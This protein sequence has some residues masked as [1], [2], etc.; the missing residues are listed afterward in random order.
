MVS[1]SV[2]TRTRAWVRLRQGA[3]VHTD[4]DGVTR[5]VCPSQGVSLGELDAAALTALTMLSDTDVDDREL[6]AGVFAEHGPSGVQGAHALLAELRAGNWLRATLEHNGTALVTVCPLGERFADD[7]RSAADLVSDVLSGM[8]RPVVRP[9]VMSRFALLRRD[10]R[11]PLLESPRSAFG[12]RIQHSPL[13]SVLGELATP[14]PIASLTPPDGL[15]PEAFAAV[16]G[17]LMACRLVVPVGSGE[18]TDFDLLQWS[19]HE[20]WFHA[21]TRRTRHESPWG[22]TYWAKGRFDPLPATHVPLGGT[23]LPLFR[24]NMDAV[25]ARDLSLTQVLETRRSLRRH[26]DTSPLTAE[27]LGEF[28]YRTARTRG[29]RT[30]EGVELIDRPYPSGG[31]LHELEIYPVVGKVSGIPAGLYRYD[32]LAHQLELLSVNSPLSRQL[33]SRAAR[34]AALPAEPQVLIVITARFGRVMWKYQSMSYALTLKNVGVLFSVMYGVATA[35]KLAPCAL[36]GGDAHL[37]G[38]AAGLDQL[39]EASVGEFLLGSADQSGDPEDPGP[40]EAGHQ[41]DI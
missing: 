9:V 16:V 17:V 7:P 40:D 39:R 33:T 36:G 22:A 10:D 1:E 30:F 28:L 29:V 35:M 13:M 3:R 37:F 20:L 25:A 34:A 14:T 24:P 2:A 8:I 41:E 11:R 18:D 27:Q 32:G 19:P 23:R 21:H 12:V 5:L 26:D 6:L 38:K 31:A 4:A 15:D